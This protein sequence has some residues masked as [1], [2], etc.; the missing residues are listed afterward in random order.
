MQI[1]ALNEASP[2]SARA[3]F[4]P[5]DDR[6]NLDAPALLSNDDDPELLIHIPFDGTVKLRAICLMGE[7]CLL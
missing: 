1:W 6:L 4:R 7:L 3:I 2:G 5:W